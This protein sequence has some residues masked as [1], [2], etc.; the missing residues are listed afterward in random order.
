[1]LGGDFHKVGWDQ[2]VSREVPVTTRIRAQSALTLCP[3]GSHVSH[4]TA[5][6]LWGAVAPTQSCTHVTLPS[7]NGRSSV[8]ESSHTTA[9]LG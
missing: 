7:M 4:H 2:Y 1:M 3:P 9:A 5:A 6:E 8:P